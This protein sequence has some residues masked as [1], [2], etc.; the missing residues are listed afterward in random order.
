MA[1]GAIALMR[2]PGNRIGPLLLAIGATWFVGTYGRVSE[3]SLSHLARSLQ[4]FYEPLLGALVLAYPSGRILGRLDR[5]VVTAWFLE[6]TAWSVSRLALS[7][8]LSW[9]GCD[10]CPETID[11][12]IANARLLNAI[13]PVSLAISIALAATVVILAARRLVA[14]GPAGR[15]RL[16]PVALASIALGAGVVLTGGIRIVVEPQLFLDP[17][18]VALMYVVETLAA[19]AVLGGLLQDR[20]ARTA[21]ADL[22]IDL[23]ADAGVGALD[24]RRLRNALARALG[25]ASLQLFPFDPDAGGYRTVAGELVELPKPGPRRAITR[26]GGDEARIAAI[27][28]DP[29]LL[30]DPGLIAA[31]TTAMRL[32]SDNRALSGEVERQVE[33]LRASR[34]R[35]VT[36]TDAERRRVERDLHDGAQQRL[37]SLSLELGRLRSAA[38]HSEDPALIAGLGT[39][40]RDLESAIEELRELARGILPP[41]L[42]DAGLGP[43]VESLVLRAAVPVDAKVELPGRLPPAIESTAYFVIAEAL[44]NVARH[45]HARRASVRVGQRDDQVAVEIVDDGVGGA[46]AGRGTGL[47]GLSDRVGALGGTLTVNSP[48]G[49]GTTLTVLLPVRA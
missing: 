33:E 11:A 41:I 16:A 2:R 8:P 5:L 48:P 26:I 6:Q 42:T 46:S 20:L 3:E 37:V 1:S 44:A 34:A 24:P 22:V 29:S 23:R 45:A 15:R 36:A 31:V 18:V 4:G 19:V 30:D 39:L 49:S 12:Y 27:A 32:E 43:A 13:A 28:H 35:I 38:A 10:T 21:V 25:D 7:R 17:A 9:Y 14:A 40:S 47:Q